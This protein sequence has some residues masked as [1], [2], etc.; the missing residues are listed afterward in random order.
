M[1][2]RGKNQVLF[3]YLPGK[4]IDYN[5][6]NAIALVER[7]FGHP[8]S[9][10]NK[11]RIIQ[12]VYKSI[13]TFKSSRGYP[14]VANPNSFELLSPVFI[15]AELFP[16]T[17]ICEQCSRA[18]S[19]GSVQQLNRILRRHKCFCGGNLTQLDLVYTHECG[20]LWAPK[21]APCKEH[22]YDSIK[23]NKHGSNSP[24]YWRWDCGVCKKEIT[25][26]NNWC[27]NCKS[28]SQVYP[29]PFRQT[30]VFTPHS[31]TLVNL[32]NL[33]EDRIYEDDIF[34]RLVIAKYLGLFSKYDTSFKECLEISPKEDNK[35]DMYIADFKAKGMSQEMINQVL[36]TMNKV[37]PN[38]KAVR[39]EIL[40]VVNNLIKPIDGDVSSLALKSYE[41]MET[42]DGSSSVPLS[43]IIDNAKSQSHPNLE[44][45]EKFPQ[46]MKMIGVDNAY[47]LNDLS[48][49]K[50]VYGFTRG[51]P[52]NEDKTLNRFAP[53]KSTEQG[54]VPIYL[55]KSDTEAILL[56][57]DRWKILRWLQVNGF[58][59]DIP[60]KSDEAGLKAWF[61]NNVNMEKITPFSEID[62]EAPI[63]R[64]VYKLLHSMCH[65]LIITGSVE[66]GLDK[67]SLAELI[68]P[69]IPAVIIYCSNVQEFQTG[70]MFTLFENNIYPWIDKTMEKVNSCI[71]DPVCMDH[72]SSCHA[73]LQL[74]E[75]SC[76]H[77]NYD[78]G[79]DV[80]IGKTTNTQK[81]IGFWSKEFGNAIKE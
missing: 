14:V 46:R 47:V 29:K 49:V 15:E 38:K 6:G 73:C 43:R 27:P 76:T 74:S 31:L 41:F 28:G 30:S 58:V 67:N 25:N 71:Y 34:K 10:V 1:M 44:K 33:N 55:S 2:R 26:L 13:R 45:I 11:T 4:P 80:L 65:S 63:T 61:L 42:L 81:L 8:V 57:F 21:V 17:F 50:T 9:D 75:F 32:H 39:D 60:D 69:S 59:K 37:S 56:E 24:Q 22:G 52:E 64:M 36:E 62:E 70:G 18:Y 16:L 68:L 20:N 72:K 12:E 40:A 48:I 77:F 51:A 23:L 5:Q 35:L 19:F 54:K 3:K 79:R 7:W 78:L 53:D 66:C